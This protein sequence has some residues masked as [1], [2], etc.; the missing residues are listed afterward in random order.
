MLIPESWL[1]AW[2][3]FPEPIEALAHRL[4]MAGLEVEDIRAKAP[5]FSGVVV[6]RILSA[7]RHPD[8][9]R[10]QV[11]RVDIG[12]AEPLQIVC[13]APNARAGITVAC[14]TDG[15]VLPGEF[16]IKKTKMR[17]VASEGM[18]CSARELGISDD[19]EG[20]IE[21]T[22]DAGLGS[23]VRQVLALD[24]KVLEIKLTPNRA[25]CLSIAGVARE[26]A[27][28]TGAAIR[29]PAW[30][31]EGGLNKGGVAISVDAGIPTPT[32]ALASESPGTAP[33]LCSRFVS[34]VIRGI[35]NTRPTPAFVAER[36]ALA[37][38]RS[39]NLVVDLSNYLMLELGQPSHAF[40]LA[41]LGGASL[42]ARF[43]QAGET[44]VPLAGE[45]PLT[46]G[47]AD[48]V[49]VGPSGVAALAGVMGGKHSG[50]SAQT[51]DI[52]LE[53]AHWLPNAIRGR[54]AAHK[55]TSEAAH[56]FERG[57]DPELP[58]STLDALTHLILTHA[59]GVA[60][61]ASSAEVA[62]APVP[63]VRLRLT[64]LEQWMGIAYEPAVVLSALQSLG[65]SPQQHTDPAQGTVFEATVPSHR[66]DIAIEEDL[67]EEVARVLG[68]EALPSVPPRASVF[69]S[70]QP[71]ALRSRQA[72]R[73][74][75]LH[76]GYTEVVTYSFISE[77]MAASY[78]SVGEPIRLLNP[79]SEPLSVMRPSLIPGLLKVVQDNAAHRQ[80]RV[81]VFEVGRVFH[82]D[83]SATA[84]D[85][86]VEGIAQPLRLGA[87]AWGPR[88]PEG[89]SSSN[90]AVDFFDVKADLEAWL[91]EFAQE[92]VFVPLGAEGQPGSATHRPDLHPGRSAE[93]R[94]LGRVV[95]VLGEVH[96]A[97]VQAAGLSSSPVVCE[98]DLQAL[99]SGRVPAAAPVVRTP[100]M[101]RDLALVVAQ[102]VPSGEVVAKL[103]ASAAQLKN[104][105][106]LQEIRVFDDY[107][108]AGLQAGEKSLG[109]RLVLQAA[110]RTLSDD[111]AD[112]LI[113]GLVE[114][115][116]K[117]FSARLR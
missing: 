69:P 26:V 21:L 36:L 27:A 34:R 33:R 47:P 84:G 39:V 83:A 90:V 45:T 61:P 64:R 40:D 96:P 72:L 110:D 97:W 48:G 99:Q 95:G 52:V 63:S 30:A 91:G 114:A 20:I 71:E 59:G 6:G 106:C 102:A 38:Q 76:R 24:E 2:V 108:G 10:L 19:S 5:P 1:R 54:A 17:G 56:R 44:L 66:F 31:P 113:A 53:C 12:A 4:T 86:Q 43:A 92:L 51:T 85:W 46:L 117:A 104:G 74:H 77:A 89:W 111:E 67:I 107:R 65:F 50:V 79:I 115:A 93:I 55:L 116:T 41:A 23:S 25:D 100:S 18:L 37:G 58:A 3:D 101:Q 57:V 87:C 80:S 73:S 42:T 28:L 81:R 16:K 112:A 82:R 109:L 49:V 7:E 32:I 103:R 98:I 8:A 105:Q 29:R 60:G 22:Q 68:Y 9:D 13:G 78:G 94:L 14:A 70:V 62:M 88:D 15:A 35:D 11:C 75:W